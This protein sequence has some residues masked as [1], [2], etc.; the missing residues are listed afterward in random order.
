MQETKR[1]RIQLEY[2]RG[3]T[4]T[5][6]DED[7]AN[8]I[9]EFLMTNMSI[10]S[11]NIGLYEEALTHSSVSTPNNQRLAFLGDRVLGIIITEY[12]FEQYPDHHRAVLN[13]KR[14]GMDNNRNF[15]KVAKEIGLIE[16]MFLGKTHQNMEKSEIENNVRIMSGAF[17]A[18]FGAIYRDQ[19]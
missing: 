12:T 8:R 11:D 7:W 1:K 6:P 3:L 18:L 17:E 2:W 9:E 5:I 10:N 4:L 19:G 15:A 13:T 14:E 16:L